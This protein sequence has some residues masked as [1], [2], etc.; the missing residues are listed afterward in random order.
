MGESTIGSLLPDRDTTFKRRLQAFAYQYDN[1]LALNL[2]IVAEGHDF[3]NALADA[4]R[5]REV[6]SQRKVGEDGFKAWD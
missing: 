6:V 2:A 5:G 1:L 3:I 4:N